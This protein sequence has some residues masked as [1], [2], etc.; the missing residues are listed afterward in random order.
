MILSESKRD[1]L[2]LPYIELLKSKGINCTLGQFKSYMLR[3]LTNEGRMRNLS[4]SSNYYLA[5]AIRYYFNGDL[6]LN[7]DLDVFNDGNTNN[8]VWNEEVCMKLNVLINILR[9]AYIDTIGETFEQ[10]EDFGTLTLPKLLRKYNKKIE[11]EIQNGS[12]VI[13]S[14]KIEDDGLDRTPT[15]GNGYTFDILYNYNQA[16]KYNSYTEPGAWCITYGKHHFDSY[17]R[18]YGIHYVIFRKDGFV[19]VNRVKGPEWTSEKPQDEYGCSLIALLQS[20]TN[21]EPVLITSRWNHGYYT[22][23]SSCEADHAFTKEEFMQKTGVTDADLQ[24]IFEI[25]KKDRQLYSD[26]DAAEIDTVSKEEKLSALRQVK[27][28][29]MRING[30]DLNVS[31]VFRIAENLMGGQDVANAKI[32]K[33]TYWC[34][35]TFAAEHSFYFLIDRGKILFDTF[36]SDDM[37]PFVRSSFGTNRPLHSYNNLV[38][39]GTKKY[40]MLFDLRKHEIINI[41]GTNK[42]KCIPNLSHGT[43]NMDPKKT[44]Y[45]VAVSKQ[46]SFIMNLATNQPLKLP[47]GSYFFNS[48][49]SSGQSGRSYNVIGR[50][51]LHPHICGGANGCFLEIY[52]DLSSGERYIYNIDERRF[53]SDN[54]IPKD[55]NNRLIGTVTYAYVPGYTVWCMVTPDMAVRGNTYSRPLLLFKNNQ[56]IS[57]GE[58]SEFRYLAYLGNGLVHFAPYTA[59]HTNRY[60][61]GDDYYVYDTQNNDF[62]KSPNGRLI[63]TTDIDSSMDT[64]ECMNSRMLFIKASGGYPS[65]SYIYDKKQKEFLKNPYN[66]PSEYLFDVE[67]Y[68]YK[69]GGGIVY[70]IVPNA[71]SWWDYNSY[72]SDEEHNEWKKDYRR[73]YVPG[74]DNSDVY[75]VGNT[76]WSGIKLDADLDNNSYDMNDIKDIVTE[77]I[78]KLINR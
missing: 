25:W 42:F 8:D 6:T 10:P 4:L 35:T 1:D 28:A 47:N 39:I 22:D 53:L 41:E 70:V 59:E 75:T 55:N 44:F 2:L 36:I 38:L 21:G 63:N 78:N 18:R 69:D 66:Y 61:G 20:N 77:V 58:Y 74:A 65:F 5:G 72:G 13:D 9:N 76:R 15:I 27:Y 57:F 40:I 51:N 73:L 34:K 49:R 19:N 11:K 43:T 54:E 17:I 33:G 3:K 16:T 7:K 23:N 71:A 52:Y 12:S 24:R 29:Q 56:Q 60:S 48:V 14:T 68:G 31:N 46:Q 50:S 26:S 67:R 64:S 30:G 37:Q 62:F 32:N 45:E